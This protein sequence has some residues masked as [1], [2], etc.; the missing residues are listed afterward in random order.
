MEPF[1]SS[2]V[3]SRFEV[4]WLFVVL[5]VVMIAERS[6][7]AGLYAEQDK[8]GSSTSWNMIG[9]LERKVLAVEG[10]CFMG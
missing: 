7:I 9:E 5:K 6:R 4:C 8:F 10:T 3:L 2:N 1:T